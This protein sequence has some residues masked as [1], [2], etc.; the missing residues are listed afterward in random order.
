M[1]RAALDHRGSRR[2]SG[3][4]EWF[5]YLFAGVTYVLFAIWHKFV[6]NWIMGPGWLVAVVVAG[7]ALWDK[8]R[9]RRA[10][11]DEGEPVASPTVGEP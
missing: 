8:V 6:L 2:L 9:G 7:P 5:W 10:V 4:E 1:G 3:A 11:P